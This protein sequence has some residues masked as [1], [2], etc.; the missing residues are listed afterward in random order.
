MVLNKQKG[1]MYG[2]VTHTWNPI[3][4]KCIHDCDYCY[5][6]VFPQ[7]D[8]HLVE[9]ELLD[10][11]GEDN[12]IF[13][14]SSTDMFA[15]NVPKEWIMKALSSCRKHNN[16]YLFQ[17]KNPIRFLEFLDFFPEKTI[18]A[19][20]LETNRETNCVNCPQPTDRA[21]AF[22]NIVF[23]RFD[24]MI[25]IEPIMDFDVPYLLEMIRDIRPKYV[26]IGADSKNHNLPEPSEFKIKLL[27]DELNTFTKITKKENLKRLTL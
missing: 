3:K 23:N 9:K 10:N 20:T 22:S 4:G 11:L 25:T 18:L 14:G 26:T 21:Y 17:T 2:F 5:M 16:Q 13:V 6:K 15:N 1:N 12:Y 19:I 8:L 7:K 24:K 27:I